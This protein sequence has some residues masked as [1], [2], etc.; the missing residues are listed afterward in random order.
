MSRLESVSLPLSSSRSESASSRAPKSEIKEGSSR[1]SFFAPIFRGL[2]LR[3]PKHVSDR[4]AGEGVE[5]TEVELLRGLGV[6]AMIASM[7]GLLDLGGKVVSDGR[8]A[9]LGSRAVERTEGFR[10]G[11]VGESRRDEDAFTLS[12]DR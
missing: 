3:T 4:E 7:S 2:L 9:R 10:H 6:L 11:S 1:A 5:S 8:S 12:K